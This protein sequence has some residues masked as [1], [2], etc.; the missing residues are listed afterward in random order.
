MTHAGMTDPE[1]PSNDQAPVP[2]RPAAR[3]LLRLHR[4]GLRLLR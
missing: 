4:Q 2:D 3:M 1:G